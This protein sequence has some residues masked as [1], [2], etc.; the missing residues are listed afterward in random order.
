[1]YMVGFNISHGHSRNIWIHLGD[2]TI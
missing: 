1:M 2:K